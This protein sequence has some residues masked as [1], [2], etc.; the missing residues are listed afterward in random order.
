MII[1]MDHFV[2]IGS[3]GSALSCGLQQLVLESAK[4]GNSAILNDHKIYCNQLVVF[5][6]S[7]IFVKFIKHFPV[8]RTILLQI[9]RLQAALCEQTEITKCSEREYER[10]QNVCLYLSSSPYHI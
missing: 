2:L 3:V 9:W 10:L 5:P 7:F 8:K 1:S 4:V 6:L